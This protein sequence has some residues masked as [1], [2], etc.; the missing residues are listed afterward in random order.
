MPIVNASDGY[1]PYFHD[2]E[3]A[4]WDPVY[5]VW[6]CP[7]RASLNLP[8]GKWY[9]NGNFDCDWY[10]QNY[11]EVVPALGLGYL[12]AK[13]TDDYVWKG[14]R[15]WSNSFLHQGRP[16]YS[17]GV[18]EGKFKAGHSLA[19]AADVDGIRYEFN[20]TEPV[21]PHSLKVRLNMNERYLDQANSFASVLVAA[22]F[23]YVWQD[24][25]L[26]DYDSPPTSHTQSI[27]YDRFLARA[28]KI[29]WI[30]SESNVG[31]MYYTLG[32]AYNQDLHYQLV[33][34]KP[35]LNQWVE[36]TTDWGAAINNMKAGVLS[37]IIN[38]NLPI[39]I[40][41]ALIL[42]YLQISTEAVGGRIGA[43]VDYAK[44]RNVV[45]G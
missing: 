5:S 6:A 41:K 9:A 2:E 29:F 31:D 44:F 3:F 39:P 34:G 10:C 25:S 40:P 7:K 21:N 36:I 16:V 26:S 23:Q 43:I 38:N 37:A 18:C 28:C 30:Y 32:D 11:A 27:H 22:L 45:D 14:G 8:S 33:I 13:S 12:Y 35:P 4:Q 42:R 19:D 24:E 1:Y 17:G 20:T 15:G